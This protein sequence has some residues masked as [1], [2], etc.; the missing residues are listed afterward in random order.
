MTRRCGFTLLELLLAMAMVAMLMLTLYTGFVT[1]FRAQAIAVRQGDA[2][3]QAKVALDLVEQDL[4]SIL[5]PK[6]GGLAG[7]FVGQPGGEA[8]IDCYPLGTDYGRTDSPTADGFRHVKFAVLADSEATN[9]KPTNMLVRGVVRAIANTAETEPEN[10]VIARNVS[11]LTVRYYDGSAW[12]DTW[13]STQQSNGLPLAV[14]LTI[15]IADP[16]STDAQHVYRLT[17]TVRLSCGLTPD[18]AAVVASAAADEAASGT[19]TGTGTSG[20]TGTGT[21]ASG[22][23]G[24]A[25]GA[26][27]GGGR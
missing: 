23:T 17:R 2:T 4:R 18:Q 15:A 10:E 6:D 12:A 3:R 9:G 20:S 7:P 25:G 24:A 14:E 26:S 22:G 13:D 11:D 21:G 5:P 1:A 27:T 8:I 19:A 16:T